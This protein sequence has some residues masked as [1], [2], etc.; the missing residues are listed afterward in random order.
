MMR[1]GRDVRIWVALAFGW[2]HGLALAHAL[3][4][5]D[6]PLRGFA[7][8][9]LSFA[10]SADAALLLVAIAVLSVSQ[11]VAARGHGSLRALTVAGSVALA[12]AGAASFVR[13]IL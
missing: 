6:R 13:D 1:G 3:T 8:G 2:V 10:I 9:A 7:W 12:L 11:L 5:M 4:A